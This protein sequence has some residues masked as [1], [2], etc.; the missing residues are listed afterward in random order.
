MSTPNYVVVATFSRRAYAQAFCDKFN[1]PYLDV[2]FN[3]GGEGLEAR[4]YEDLDL[5]GI[6]QE[7]ANSLIAYLT[8]NIK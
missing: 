8:R 4:V 1:V 5:Q 2:I 7:Q 6:N 3:H